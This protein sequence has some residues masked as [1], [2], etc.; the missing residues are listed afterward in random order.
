M[1]VAHPGISKKIGVRLDGCGFQIKGFEVKFY[2]NLRE[3]VTVEK[4]S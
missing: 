4:V 1:V 2:K 3:L